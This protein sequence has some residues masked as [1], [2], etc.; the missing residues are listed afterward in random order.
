MFQSHR[1]QAHAGTGISSEFQYVHLEER[2][3]TNARYEVI[4]ERTAGSD[5]VIGVHEDQIPNPG[6]FDLVK[7]VI[8]DVECGRVAAI[9]HD[10]S[11]IT[12]DPACTP[13]RC[14]YDDQIFPRDA[15]A[16][17]AE[18]SCDEATNGDGD[19]G[20]DAGSESDADPGG[21]TDTEESTGGSG[22]CSTLAPTTPPAPWLLAIGLLILPLS[23]RRP[24]SLRSLGRWA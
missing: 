23:P 24:C 16:W 5:F 18:S 7:A 15:D 12:S 17:E 13:H 4:F 20:G 11:R 22:G 2:V 9:L 3:E 10:G 1:R 21:S 8:D 14:D 19:G 6:A